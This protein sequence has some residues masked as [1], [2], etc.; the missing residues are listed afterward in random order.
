MY[1]TLQS[2]THQVLLL[3]ACSGLRCVQT[4]KMKSFI[5]HIKIGTIDLPD[6]KQE[7]TSPGR[8]PDFPPPGRWCHCWYPSL[9]QRSGVLTCLHHPRPRSH[10]ALE[11]YPS[12]SLVIPV[13]GRNIWKCVIASLRSLAGFHKRVLFQRLYALVLAAKPRG[14]WWGVELAPSLAH[15][16][17]SLMSANPAG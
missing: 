10:T 17:I 13:N 16:K 11:C 9:F 5:T 3:Q 7:K 2:Q 6:E 15:E 1:T 14:D 8:S 4:K 12:V